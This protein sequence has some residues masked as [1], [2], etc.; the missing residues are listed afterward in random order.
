MN[1]CTRVLAI[2]PGRDKCGLAVVDRQAGVLAHTVTPTERLQPAA[3]QWLGEYACKVVVVGDGTAS[4]AIRELLRG[5]EASRDI[6]QVVSVDER[7]S[8]LEAR[9][10]YWRETPPRGWRRLFPAGLLPPPCAIDDYAAIILAE[11]FFQN[12]VKN[13]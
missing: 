3:R 5:M 4:A 8:T 11:R 7:N 2:D 6:A 13:L 1:S 10:R 9:T 12:C